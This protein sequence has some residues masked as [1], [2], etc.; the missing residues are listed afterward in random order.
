MVHPADVIL[1]FD[2]DEELM[3]FDSLQVAE[4]RLEPAGVASS[5]Y[6]AY[7]T[8]GRVVDLLTSEEANGPVVALRTEAHDRRELERRLAHYWHRH[9]SRTVLSP[10]E[11]VRLLLAGELP[12]LRRRSWLARILHHDAPAA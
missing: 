1:V 5:A 10:E 3:V 9:G 8:D 7:T 12:R 6:A 4:E 2:R 11:T